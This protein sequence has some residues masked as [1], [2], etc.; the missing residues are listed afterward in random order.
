MSFNFSV[1]NNLKL[2][3]SA[4]SPRILRACE[5]TPRKEN[6]SLVTLVS[7]KPGF[8]LGMCVCVLPRYSGF[9][10]MFICL[11]GEN[12]WLALVV[13]Y[14]KLTITLLMWPFLTLGINCES[15]WLKLVMHEALVLLIYCCILPDSTTS[16]AGT[17]SNLRHTLW[18]CSCLPQSFH[19]AWG[20][21][22]DSARYAHPDRSRNSIP[23][24]GFL[25][26]YTAVH[27]YTCL[28]DNTQRK[29]TIT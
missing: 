11:Y 9:N 25:L 28:A 15:L 16:R 3:L 5:N 27:F 29:A 20:L 7:S 6:K 13:V 24:I 17:I 10:W 12:M 19:K 26:N 8:V 22:R 2:F 23:K 18:S 1:K 21:Y 4:H 14:I